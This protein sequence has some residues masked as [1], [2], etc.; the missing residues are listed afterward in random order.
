[1]FSIKM[2][3]FSFLTYALSI[4]KCKF[5]DLICIYRWCFLHCVFYFHSCLCFQDFGMAE[6]FATK[7]LELKPKSY[8]AYYA[9]AR[10]K[11][12][13]RWALFVPCDYDHL[14]FSFKPVHMG[15]LGLS[16]R[17]AIK[18][19]NKSIYKNKVIIL[20]E[21]VITLR[22]KIVNLWGKSQ[23]FTLINQNK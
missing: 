18:I 20:W 9:R 10:A 19:K 21:K 6:E 2:F 4:K 12:S 22:E 11:R 5:L 14:V 23:H 17:A 8:E 3:M 7:A 13:S 16:I 1:M 15:F